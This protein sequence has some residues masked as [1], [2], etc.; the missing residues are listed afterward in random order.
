MWHDNPYFLIALSGGPR[1]MG[2]DRYFELMFTN[3][4]SRLLEL[5]AFESGSVEL[6]ITV[7]RTRAESIVNSRESDT[8]AHD[9]LATCDELYECMDALLADLPTTVRENDPLTIADV[10]DKDKVKGHLDTA[11]QI[12]R[13]NSIKPLKWA[14]REQFL[15]RLLLQ[16]LEVMPEAVLTARPPRGT[17]AIVDGMNHCFYAMTRVDYPSLEFFGLES[18]PPDEDDV[19]VWYAI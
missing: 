7:V 11:R 5:W 2:K 18:N 16:Y 8:S 19:Q 6:A 14:I 4:L 9:S 12:F 1:F 15:P 3:I 10:V 13:D 17:I